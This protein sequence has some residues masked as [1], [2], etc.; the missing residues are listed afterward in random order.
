MSSPISSISSNRA[1]LCPHG[2]PPAACPICSGGGMA[3]GGRKENVATKPMKSADWSYAKCLAVGLQMQAQEA[4]VE[5]AKQAFDRQIEFAK[6]LGKTINNISENIKNAIQNFQNT[7]PNALKI[8]MEVLTNIVITPLLNL[9]AQVPKVL[10]KLAHFQKDVREFIQQA[11][12]KLV[13]ILGEIKNFVDKKV[14]DKIKKKVKSIFDF[15]ISDFEGEN[16]SNDDAL[17][18][19]KTRELRKHLNKILKIHKKRDNDVHRRI[20][21]EAVSKH[22]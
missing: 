2:L 18:V 20:E 21:S 1:G 10:E 5:N 9:A 8:P 11:G 17:A 6:Q 22:I 3:A 13:A 14:M 19:F 16:Y 12:E 4:R 15:F 7:L